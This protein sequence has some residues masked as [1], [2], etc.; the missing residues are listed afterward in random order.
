M[1]VPFRPLPVDQ[2]DVRYL[3]GPDSVRQPGVPAGRTIEFDWADSAAYPGTARKF[4]VHLPARSVAPS[5][6]TT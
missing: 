2:S 3:H 1:Q 6:W 5:S 4:W